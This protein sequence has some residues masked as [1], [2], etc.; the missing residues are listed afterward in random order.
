MSWPS[1]MTRPSVGCLEAR[2]HAQ[3]RSLAA[4]GRAEQ[5]EELALVNVEREIVDGDEVTKPLGHIFKTDDRL[6]GWILPRREPDCGAAVRGPALV[7]PC[8]MRFRCS[9]PMIQS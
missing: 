3:Q 9:V 6:L 5:R 1:T 7:R 4:T 8:P 2:Q